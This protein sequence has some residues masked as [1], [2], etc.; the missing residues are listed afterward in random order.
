M[1]IGSQMPGPHPRGEGLVTSAEFLGS[2]NAECFLQT[3]NHIAE[4]IVLTW[5]LHQHLIT[6]YSICL[7]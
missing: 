2:I 1:F 4:T 3:A 5:S 6:L 7:I